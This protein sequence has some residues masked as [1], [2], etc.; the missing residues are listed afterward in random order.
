[1]GRHARGAP[2]PLHSWGH[3]RGQQRCTPVASKCTND[4]TL[5]ENFGEAWAVQ[6]YAPL[7]FCDG[8]GRRARFGEPLVGDLTTSPMAVYAPDPTW[9]PSFPA[10]THTFSAVAVHEGSVFV[11]QRGNLTVDPILMLS[12]DTGRVLTSWGSNGDVAARGGTWG[13]HGLQ[14]DASGRIWVDDFFAG[15]LSAFDGDGKRLLVASTLGRTSNG[16][17]ESPLQFGSVADTVVDGESVYSSDGDGGTNNRCVKMRIGSDMR[18]VLEWTTPPIFDNP[19]SLAL[20]VRSGVLVVA[21]REHTSTRLL[22]ASD[23]ADLGAW[24]CGLARGGKPFGL[25]FFRQRDYL[26]LSTYDNPATGRHQRI[27]VID[28]SVLSPEWV[29]A[30]DAAVAAG[31]LV[32]PPPCRVLQRMPI[33]PIVHSGPHLLG[34]DEANGDV[35]AA[36]VADAPRSTVLRFRLVQ[37]HTPPLPPPAPVCAGCTPVFYPGL[38]TGCNCFRIPTILR[39]HRG[40]LLAFAESR[41]ASCDDDGPHHALV[42]RRS[43]PR[44][45]SNLPLHPSPHRSPFTTPAVS[46]TKPSPTAQCSLL[47][48]AVL[49]PLTR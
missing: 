30:A 36:L 10:G 37:H 32:T 17:T 27:S 13:S 48:G 8:R 21:D 23:G 44:S 49:P 9:M 38:C 24:D 1:M 20:H 28:A 2:I 16:S 3:R 5:T 6:L 22:R 45:A 4:T 35:Y 34:I 47:C 33:D 15:T 31:Q 19:H 12:S 25:R 7:G 14:V 39:T 46:R 40:T 18:P 43:C 42:L 26:L 41:H 11:S 29:H